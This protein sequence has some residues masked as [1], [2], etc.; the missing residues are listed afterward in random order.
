MDNL[1][2]SDATSDTPSISDE[3]IEEF[4]ERQH[5]NRLNAQRKRA[6]KVFK[7]NLRKFLSFCFV[8]VI[9]V[10]ILLIIFYCTKNYFSLPELP[11]GQPT[12]APT[13]NTK[14]SIFPTGPP[15]VGPGPTNE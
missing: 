15:L 8:V 5:T 6:R 12:D 1:E 9:P 10:V 11:T 7:K 14:S 2:D 3:P 13:L 4:L